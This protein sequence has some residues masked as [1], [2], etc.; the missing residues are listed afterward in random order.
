MLVNPAQ[1]ELGAVG[2]FVL[3][4]FRG[5]TMDE[6]AFVGIDL[7]GTLLKVVIAGADGTI[8]ARR[9]APTKA[10]ADREELLHQVADLVEELR[11]EVRTTSQTRRLV[12]VGLAV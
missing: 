3:A 11:S 9:Q 1:H 10:R 7:G 4:A 8:L 2:P 6:P 5:G 12:A